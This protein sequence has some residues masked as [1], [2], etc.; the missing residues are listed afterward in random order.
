VATSSTNPYTSTSRK[1]W[2]A[3]EIARHPRGYDRG[4]F[5]FEPR[6][7]LALLEQKPGPLGPLALLHTG[8]LPESLQHLRRPLEA[9][10]GFQMLPHQF[11]SASV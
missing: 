11:G 8:I 10:A 9:G 3:V 6:H 5:I 7:Y 1:P 2:A 4:E